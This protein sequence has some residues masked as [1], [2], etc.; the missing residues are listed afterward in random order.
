MLLLRRDYGEAGGTVSVSSCQDAL[1]TERDKETI[2]KVRRE[3]DALR[4]E[5]KETKLQVEVLDAVRRSA[6]EELE[7][8]RAVADAVE[9]ALGHANRMNG[10]WSTT[11][12]QQI[13]KAQEIITLERAVKA[14]REQ[15]PP[16]PAAGA[17]E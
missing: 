3:R 14:W 11:V 7:A 12:G 9:R 5:V 13:P 1:F 8:L 2:D 17:A 6:N 4:A 16:P 10:Y 15:F